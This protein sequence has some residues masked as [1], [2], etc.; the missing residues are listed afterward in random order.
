PLWHL[1]KETQM[2]KE[3]MH[4]LLNSFVVVAVILAAMMF[5]AP[6]SANAQENNPW[7]VFCQ[8]GISLP[9][10]TDRTVLSEDS[11]SGGV[12]AYVEGSSLMLFANY[13]EFVTHVGAADGQYWFV[14]GLA[15]T[16]D[17]QDPP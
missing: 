6:E 17:P 10:N 13:E 5:V 1:A 4:K 8:G 2:R 12:F 11:C 3:T 15:T 16:A 9:G 14:P 7:E